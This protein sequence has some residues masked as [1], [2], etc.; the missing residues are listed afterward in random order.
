MTGRQQVMVLFLSLFFSL[1]FFLTGAF[2][3]FQG[4]KSSS[5]EEDLIEKSGKKFLVEVDGSVNRRGIYPIK[6]GISVLEVI[7]KAGGIKEKLSFAPAD[8]LIP[9]AKN[10]R[11]NIHPAGDGKGQVSI[12]SLDADKLPIL[13]LPIFLNTAGIEELDTLPGIGPKT[14]QAIVEYRKIHG[15]FVSPADLLQVR[16]IGPKKLSEILPHITL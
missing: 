8:L 1:F 5:R 6:A 14:A 13:S 2:F 9:I 7:E 11:V 15:K 3:T 10:C 4:G 12:E 16:G